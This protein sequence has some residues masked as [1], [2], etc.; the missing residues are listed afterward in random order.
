MMRWPLRRRKVAPR[1]SFRMPA[2]I[3][4]GAA[5]GVGRGLAAVWLLPTGGDA[6]G[7]LTGIGFQGA[8][9]LVPLLLPIISAVVALLA[10][11]FAAGRALRTFS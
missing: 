9:W 6:P 8:G 10:T 3:R 1:S 11:A 5:V 7:F 4:A 2:T